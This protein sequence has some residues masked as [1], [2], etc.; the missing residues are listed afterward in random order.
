MNHTATLLPDGKVLVAGGY[1]FASTGPLAS[2][3]LYNPDSGT[4]STTG[5]LAD[6]RSEDTATLLPDGTVLVAGGFDIDGT[7][8]SAELYDPASETWSA[9][10]SLR[11]PTP[12]SH[13][14]AAARWYG[15]GRRR[16]W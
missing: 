16:F 4:W 13:S 5:S 14:D 11:V 6:A 9:T 3:K 8:A 2:A 15:A 1:N 10:D 7:L 12:E